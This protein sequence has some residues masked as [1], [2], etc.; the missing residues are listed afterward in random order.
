[1]ATAML[2]SSTKPSP[3]RMRAQH[4]DRH[5]GARMRARRPALSWLLVARVQRRSCRCSTS[6]AD[7]C[8]P[9]AIRADDRFWLHSAVRGGQRA[10]PLSWSKPTFEPPCQ[11]LIL[12]LQLHAG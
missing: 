1:M 8:H 12:L 4:T 2:K 6:R 11:L 10:R 9:I 7:A 3:G 5:V